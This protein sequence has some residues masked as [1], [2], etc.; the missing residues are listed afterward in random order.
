[1]SYDDYETNPLYAHER[2]EARDAQRYASSFTGC[3]DHNHHYVPN[4]RGG[5]ICRDCGDELSA[6]EL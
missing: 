3:G 6:E 5:G 2:E 4:G 1:M